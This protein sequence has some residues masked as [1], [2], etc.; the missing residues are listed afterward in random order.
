MGGHG[1]SV[2]LATSEAFEVEFVCIPRPVER[3]DRVYGGPVLYRTRHRAALWRKDEVPQIHTTVV[4]RDP[5]LS[6]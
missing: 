4:E 2:V 6:I 5:R 3:S 1:Y